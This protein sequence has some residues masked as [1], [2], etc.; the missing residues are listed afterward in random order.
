MDIRGALEAEDLLK[1]VLVLVVVWIVVEIVIEILEFA[2]GPFRPLIGL[3][4]VLV[5][6]LWFLDVL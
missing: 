1:V 3:I 4:V 2:L 5:I 6:V